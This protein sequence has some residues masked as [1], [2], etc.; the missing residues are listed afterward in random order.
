[1][2]A[3]AICWPKQSRRIGALARSGRIPLHCRPLQATIPGATLAL[4][5]PGGDVQLTCKVRNIVGPKHIRDASGVLRSGYELVAEKRTIRYGRQVTTGY[6]GIK[7]RAIGQLHY[8]DDRTWKSKIIFGP[9]SDRNYLVDS[10][11]ASGAVLRTKPFQGGV[12]GLSLSHPESLLVSR[13]VDWI[14]SPDHFIHTRS[15][16]SGL[17]ADLFNTTTWTLFE[18]KANVRDDTVREAFG[19]LYDYKRDFMRAPS[20]AVLLPIKPAP[21]LNSF[22]KHFGVATVWETAR[23]FR[24]S[25]SGRLTRELRSRY[26]QVR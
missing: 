1:M 22:L 26:R 7:W 23:G 4:V 15:L 8:F 5:S 11:S 17:Y 21:R 14:S 10:A 9:G 19:Q 20:L 6:L 12:P 18:A 3:I 24:D 25:V 2:N 16:S 13:Y